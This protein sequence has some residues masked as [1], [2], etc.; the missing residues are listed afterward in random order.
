MKQSKCESLTLLYAVSGFG[1]TTLVGSMAEW[2]YHKTGLRTRLVSRSGGGWEVVQY[3]VDAGIIVPTDITSRED[4]YNLL[5]KLSHGWWPADHTDPESPLLCPY[6]LR[7]K[8]TKWKGGFQ[9]AEDWNGYVALAIDGISEICEWIMSYTVEREAKG[10]MKVS[11][12]SLSS[13]FAD[14]DE[15]YGG[16]GKGQYGTIQNH[17]SMCVTNTKK[18]FGKHVLWTAL[19]IRTK[20]DQTGMPI[21]GPDILGKAK[22]SNAVGWAEQTLHGWKDPKSARRRLYLTS[23]YDEYGIEFKAKNT[24]SHHNPLPEFLEGSD[25]SLGHFMNKLDES[26]KKT[27]QRVAALRGVVTK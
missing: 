26:K 4:R 21:Y 14:G 3:L 22:T 16:P 8:Y 7:D 1:K 13:V 9:T 6:H 12:E 19:E 2:L 17:M 20:D 25:L 27:A 15:K 18:L 10:L 24:A 23:H 5:D 11:G